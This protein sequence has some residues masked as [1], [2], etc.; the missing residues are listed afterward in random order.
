MKRMV[1]VPDHQVVGAAAQREDGLHYE[2]AGGRRVHDEL[3]EVRGAGG[4]TVAGV[5]GV[6]EC[7]P[8]VASWPASGWWMVYYTTSITLTRADTR[9]RRRL[10]RR[11]KW[12]RGAAAARTQGAGS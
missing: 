3:A 9:R 8:Q 7:C 12:R 5:G 2:A 4:Y 10:T 1:L 11:L 6:T